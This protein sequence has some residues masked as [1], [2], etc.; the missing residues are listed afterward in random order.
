ML[1]KEFGFKPDFDNMQ[2]CLCKLSGL[3]TSQIEGIFVWGE[4]EIFRFYKFDKWEYRK[5]ENHYI[6]F[7]ECCLE[8]WSVSKEEVISGKRVMY[9]ME[10]SRDFFLKNFIIMQKLPGKFDGPQFLFDS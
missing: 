5:K 1:R 4:V 7:D 8:Q 9:P 3:F 6:V 10:M 2:T